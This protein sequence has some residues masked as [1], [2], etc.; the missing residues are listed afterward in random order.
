MGVVVAGSSCFVRAISARR[1]CLVWGWS[2]LVLLGPW[3]CRSLEIFMTE[4]RNRRRGVAIVLGL[5]GAAGL[6]VASAAQLNLTGGS[7]VAQAGT[8]SVEGACQS[9]SIAVSFGLDGAAAGD[10]VTG[11]AGFGFV[12]GADTI[13]LDSVDAA[14]AGKTMRVALGD[15]TGGQWGT[16]YEVTSLV[17]GVQVIDIADFGPADLT[18]VATV[19][20]TIFD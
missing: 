2:V 1:L 8:V 13:E 10:L 9:S 15:V 20:V 19:A 6:V 14:C 5:A 17:P 7:S 3:S 11:G 4:R 12:S 16:T 18:G